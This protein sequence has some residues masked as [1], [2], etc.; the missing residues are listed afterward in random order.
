[1]EQAEPAHAEG[2]EQA[3]HADSYGVE[4]AFM[5]AIEGQRNG[6][7]APEVRIASQLQMQAQARYHDRSAVKVIARMNHKLDIRRNENPTP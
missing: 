4:Q 1:V 2:V 6:P 3:E 7:S 5:P